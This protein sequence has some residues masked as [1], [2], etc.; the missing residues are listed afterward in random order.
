M[1]LVLPQTIKILIL[2]INIHAPG[3]LNIAIGLY[4]R[5]C[6]ILVTGETNEKTF[7]DCGSGFF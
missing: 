3:L 5:T 6:T 4:G 7:R 1:T 2:S